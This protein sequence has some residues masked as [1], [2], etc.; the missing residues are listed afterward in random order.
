MMSQKTVVRCF[1]VISAVLVSLT[2][3]T[4]MGAAFQNN[5]QSTVAMGRANAG[6]ASYAGDIAGIYINPA[7]LATIPRTQVAIGSSV[8]FYHRQLDTTSATSFGNPIEGTDD[9]NSQTAYLPSF[10]YAQPLFNRASN[11]F[12][13]GLA[14]TTPFNTDNEYDESSNARYLSTKS[15]LYTIDI[16]P[17]VA[18]LVTPRISVGAG[19]SAQYLTTQ[20]D[21][22]VDL[23]TRHG[24]VPGGDPNFDGH[25]SNEG[26]NWG[27]GFNFGVL[28]RATQ[29]T[30]VGLS[31]RS[32]V[33][34][35]IDGDS[36]VSTV[37]WINDEGF[38]RRVG[39]FD[40]GFSLSMYMPD[41]ITMSATHRMTHRWLMML[42]LQYT[43]W[44]RLDELDFEYSEDEDPEPI[45]L[46][47]QN[48]IRVSLGTEYK[49]YDRA[50]QFI[51]RGGGA[52][53]QS[54]VSDNT[55][56]IAI[57][58]SDSVDM[59]VGLGWCY[60]RYKADLAYIYTY[61]WEAEIDESL[62]NST[63]SGTVINER[64]RLALQFTYVF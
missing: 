44:S 12:W 42:D 1:A 8:D 52:Y 38:L 62:D 7:L 39:Y 15:F 17:S 19:F 63:Y 13:F 49:L 61:Y 40:Q 27:Y 11:R 16:N 55:S 57:P 21:H 50:Y 14:V 2:T 46:D 32:A 41:I 35:D 10:Y 58:D 30:D 33:K 20:F 51:L 29:R 60:G 9:D 36:T 53:A 4:A 23:G 6:E 45:E 18:Y 24:G 56:T 48:S 28:W 59:A 43:L 54:P 47:W 22:S 26:D 5:A 3:N 37:D 34:H 31:Y 25:V 64:N